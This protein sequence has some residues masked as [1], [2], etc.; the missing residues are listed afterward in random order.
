VARSEGAS[1]SLLVREAAAALGALGDDAAG[2]VTACRRLVDR[3][4]TVG[5]MWWLAARVLTAGD[6]VGEAW[7]VVEDLE[8]DP[9][10]RVLAACLPDDARVTVLGWPEQAVEALRRRGDVE[11]LL[12]D[13]GGEAAGLARR[14]RSQG[15]STTD[16]ADAG[17]GAAV[18]SCGVLL[19]ESSAVGPTGFLAVS[20]SYAAAAVARH[21]G[22]PVWVVAGEGRVLPARL[23]E[24][25]HARLGRSADEPW[26]R[27]DDVVA[28]G[29][30]DEVIGPGG[31]QPAADA[32]RLADCPVAPELLRV[33]G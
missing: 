13:C 20:S 11:V 27:L 5:P 14:L 10:P 19:L 32:P 6:P 4:P 24:A 9:T 23:W 1:P 33:P 25:M 7:R 26:E 29:L 30:A 3:H 8:R 18:A 22:V 28:L 15:M 12:V 16:V 17:L 21:A 31:R 2:M